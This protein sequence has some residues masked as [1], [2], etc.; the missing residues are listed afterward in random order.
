M[1]IVF[2]LDGYFN[3]ATANPKPSLN[4]ETI[5][6][7]PGTARP[8]SPTRR[9]SWRGRQAAT[10]RPSHGGG[11]SCPSRRCGARS[12]HCRPSPH[13][14][15][16]PPPSLLPL[17]NRSALTRSDQPAAAFSPAC[18]ASCPRGKR[19]RS[20]LRESTSTIWTAGRSTQISTFPN[21][22]PNATA[23]VSHLVSM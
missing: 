4:F 8:S 3:I 14:H 11:G 2:F 21:T 1:S 20:P 13:P 5:P 6:G 7:V 10:S 17:L 19:P 22:T 16:R 15:P 18:S 23:R 9:W 12:P